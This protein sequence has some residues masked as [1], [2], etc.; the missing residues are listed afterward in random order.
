MF[1]DENRETIL[2]V[3]RSLRHVKMK[4]I[5]SKMKYIYIQGRNQK[6][7]SVGFYP[8]FEIFVWINKI[9]SISQNKKIKNQ[10]SVLASFEVYFLLK[11]LQFVKFCQI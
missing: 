5:V 11:Y 1:F 10:N 3:R 8:P 9:L 7:G 2:A 6:G 4:T